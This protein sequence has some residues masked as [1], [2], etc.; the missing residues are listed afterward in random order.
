MKLIAVLATLMLAVA[1]EAGFVTEKQYQTE[2]T[3]WV[4]TH[5]KKYMTSDFFH[6]Y[7]IFKSNLDII[8]RHNS[9]AGQTFTL[10]P[11]KFTDL[12]S[13]E[14]AAK[15]NGFVGATKSGKTMPIDKLALVNAPDSLDWREKGA[16]TAV[17]DQGQ[18]GSWS[19]E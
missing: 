8:E 15:M 14:F 12:T 1:A 18:C 19:V 11:N 4:K 2:F 6:R 5:N 10:G 3:R 16:V 9:Q 7:E 13:E 17:K